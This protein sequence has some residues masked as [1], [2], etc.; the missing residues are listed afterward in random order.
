MKASTMLYLQ[1]SIVF[2]LQKSALL[3]ITAGEKY[4]VDIKPSQIAHLILSRFECSLPLYD[5]GVKYILKGE[6]S[7]FRSHPLRIDFF[8]PQGSKERSLFEK[9]LLTRGRRRRSTNLRFTCE[10]DSMGRVMRANYLKMSSKQVQELGL[11]DELMG[12]ANVSYVTRHQITKLASRIYSDLNIVEEYEIPEHS[13]SDLFTN[14]LLRQAAGAQFTYVP[15]E[16]ALAQMSSFTANIGKDLQ[17]TEI[18][19]DLGSILEVARSDNKSHIVVNKNF[20]EA[21]KEQGKT[22]YSGGGQ[23]SFLGI[24]NIDASVKKVQESSRD[25]QQANKS[26]NDQLR[27]LNEEAQSDVKWAIK[28]SQ[29]VPKSIEVAKVSR[30]SFEKTLSFQ[31]VR[32]QFYAAPFS[33]KTALYTYRA[34][35]PASLSEQMQKAIDSMMSNI[36]DIA[37]KVFKN[38]V[39]LDELRNQE[40]SLGKELREATSEQNKLQEGSNIIRER[41]QSLEAAIEMLKTS[42]LKQCRI[43]F[44][45]T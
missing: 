17:A 19:E 14:E 34:E 9:R 36:T 20:F 40:Q 4:N 31:R 8:A 2:S 13:F 23:G 12:P 11:A 35:Q 1:F 27:I 28:G 43:C 24:I 30:S 41:V 15:V 44:Q 32:K 6:V 7:D 33:R 16:Q 37:G 39:S 10:M 5:N 42:T 26:L 25:W 18:T 29:I 21:L 38:Q 3:A 45:A 22:D